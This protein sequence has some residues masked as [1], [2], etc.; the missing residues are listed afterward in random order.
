MTI[1]WLAFVIVVA[2]ALV[3]ASLVV[4]LFATALRLGD[5]D[6]AWRR[7]VAVCLYVLCAGVVL[8]GLYLIIPALHV[9]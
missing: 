3:A 7:P 1:D 5:G 9:K 4:T 2:T 8:F 6:A